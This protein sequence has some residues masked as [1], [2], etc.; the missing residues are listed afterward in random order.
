MSPPAPSFFSV[1]VCPAC[2]QSVELPRITAELLFFRASGEGVALPAVA[3]LMPDGAR[4][5]AFAGVI[6]AMTSAEWD[7]Y[8]TMRRNWR[9]LE[10][11][12][13]AA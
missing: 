4:A 3:A 6:Y 2:G 7:Q 11:D 13:I 9:P 5:V 1:P 12:Q 10:L 8:Q